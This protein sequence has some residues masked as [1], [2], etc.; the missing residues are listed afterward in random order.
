MPDRGTESDEPRWLHLAKPGILKAS[1]ARLRLVLLL[2]P[3]L[4]VL[5]CDGGQSGE[6]LQE[7][8]PCEGVIFED[9]DPTDDALGFS[10]EALVAS[11]VSPVGVD[12]TDLAED[13]TATDT[14]SFEGFAME[15]TVRIA[16][17]GAVRPDCQLGQGQKLVVPVGFDVEI[18]DGN[19]VGHGTIELWAESLAP[20]D[21]LPVTDWTFPV[22]LSGSYGDAYAAWWEAEQAAHPEATDWS[23]EGAWLI[24]DQPWDQ[25]RMDIEVQHRSS[26][27]NGLSALWRGDAIFEVPER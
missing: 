3:L 23:L 16:D 2:L 24:L 18:G 10:A 12:W 4:G 19:V 22:T 17:L 7:D 14:L 21:I 8:L 9:V 26:N 5:G 25:L 1:E 11:L 6:N 15:G 13:G 27:T 20:A